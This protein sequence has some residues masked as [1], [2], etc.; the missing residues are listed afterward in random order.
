MPPPT[1]GIDTPSL[2]DALPI[3]G[4]AFK[5]SDSNAIAIDTVAA[6]GTLTAPSGRKS[7]RG[8]M[9]GIAT[10]GAA[11][12]VAGGGTGALDVKQAILTTPSGSGS[13]AGGSGILEAGG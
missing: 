12:G 6:A 11:V 1:T 4:K 7:N 9:S 13:T 5:Y 3:S 8:T 2:H 10:L